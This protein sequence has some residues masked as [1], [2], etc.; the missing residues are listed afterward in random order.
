MEEKSK[1]E[2][3]RLYMSELVTVLVCGSLIYMLSDSSMGQLD[4]RLIIP[5]SILIFIILQS[6]GYWYYRYRL[7]ENPGTDYPWVMPLFSIFKKTNRV[8]FFSYPIF[9]IYLL[10]VDQGMLFIPMNIFGLILYGFSILE[11]INYFYYNVTIGNLRAKMPSDL[12]IELSNY[13]VTK[14]KKS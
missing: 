13:E 6:A 2:L 1:K 4:I 10:I 8:L 3:N 5:G 14:G 9:C 7:A 11:N 12:A